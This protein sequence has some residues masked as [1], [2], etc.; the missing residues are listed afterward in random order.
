MVDQ[1]FFFPVTTFKKQILT[2]EWDTIF[3]V[4][5]INLPV[6]YVSGDQDELVPH[7]MT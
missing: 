2:M 7:W 3:L 4:D 1:L 6:M 5:K